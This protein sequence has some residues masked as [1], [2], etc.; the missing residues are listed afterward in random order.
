MYTF[1]GDASGKEPTC[2][3]RRHK[4]YRFDPW[5]WKIPW[6]GHSNSLQYFAWREEPGR[7]QSIGPQ[8]VGHNWSDLECTHIHKFTYM[9]PEISLW[10]ILK[11]YYRN[12]W[13]SVLNIRNNSGVKQ[14]GS[15]T[16]I[17]LEE[18]LVN[19]Y[20]LEDPISHIQIHRIKIMT[21]SMS[22]LLI[23]SPLSYSLG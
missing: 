10:K 4:R 22:Q 8:R 16:V 14:H 18:G 11:I 17:D 12:H 23:S 15:H 2:Q 5:V 6:R 19:W 7:L 9:Y 21:E 3:C 20:V 13:F 1:P